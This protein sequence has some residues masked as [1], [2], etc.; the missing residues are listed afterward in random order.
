MQ[1]PATYVPTDLDGHYAIG[2]KA[3]TVNVPV[4]LAVNPSL[5]LRILESDRKNLGFS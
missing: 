3:G 4:Q 2:R 1:S 5:K